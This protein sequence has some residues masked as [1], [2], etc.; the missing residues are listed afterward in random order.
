MG[1]RFALNYHAHFSVPCQKIMI[2]QLGPVRV[3]AIRHGYLALTQG[4][5]DKIR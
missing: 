3:H 4:E 5:N 2:S 1:A